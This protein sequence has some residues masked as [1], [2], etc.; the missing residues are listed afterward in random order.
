MLKI[1]NGIV[2]LSILAN[3]EW[4]YKLSFVSL[5]PSQNS[6]Q[7]LSRSQLFLDDFGKFDNSRKYEYNSND[8][9]D[10]IPLLSFVNTAQSSK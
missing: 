4:G 1:I 3:T 9:E 5:P 8:F 7:S 6:S 2:K 10:F